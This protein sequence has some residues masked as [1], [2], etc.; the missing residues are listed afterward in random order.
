VAPSSEP[1]S[2][3]GSP[4]D[5]PS[6]YERPKHGAKAPRKYKRSKTYSVGLD[7]TPERPETNVASDAPSEESDGP[8]AAGLV[9]LGAAAAL[10]AAGLVI[11]RRRRT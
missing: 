9:G 3:T 6:P 11:A 8:P 7:V 4:D 2:A 5:E 1:A 10:G